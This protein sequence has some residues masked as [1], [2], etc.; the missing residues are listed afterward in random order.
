MTRRN[1]FRTLEQMLSRCDANNDLTPHALRHGF[2]SILLK[3]G[4]EIKTISELM[5]HKDI[6]TTYNVYIGITE[7]Q[8]FD[9]IK[10]L[11]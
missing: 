11:D 4:V 3:N 9:A 5:G 1:I 6:R 10:T 7:Q 2:G 8:K